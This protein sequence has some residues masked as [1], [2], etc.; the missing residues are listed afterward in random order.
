[1]RRSERVG[2]VILLVVTACGEPDPFVPLGVV[3]VK[4]NTHQDTAGTPACAHALEHFL[5]N[6]S[7]RIVQ[8]VAP[9]DGTA[10]TERLF[11]IYTRS[12]QRW[13]LASDMNVLPVEEPIED[14][15]S[16]V[17]TLRWSKGRSLYVVR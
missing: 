5:A 9:E 10:E 14:K 12:D 11:V 3:E 16:I 13:P 7:S 6:Y 2:V 1:M 4:C 8:V 15:R 17:I